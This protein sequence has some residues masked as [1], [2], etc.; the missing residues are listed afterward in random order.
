VVQ[1][2]DP[3]E[4]WDAIALAK[5]AKFEKRIKAELAYRCE[6]ETVLED[7]RVNKW[8]RKGAELYNFLNRSDGTIVCVPDAK[9]EARACG[10]GV[11]FRS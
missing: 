10:Y 9:A 1:G 3:V 8:H 11:A 2:L 4:Q 6:L 7:I 5:W